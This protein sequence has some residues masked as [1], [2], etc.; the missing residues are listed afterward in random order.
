MNNEISSQVFAGAE[1]ATYL[2]AKRETDTTIVFTPAQGV[3]VRIGP[4]Q[5]AQ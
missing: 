4:E 1:F 3:L 5:I 2:N